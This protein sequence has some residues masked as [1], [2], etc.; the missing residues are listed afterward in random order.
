MKTVKD[1]IAMLQTLDQDTILICSKDA[2]GNSY[3][4][5]SSIGDGYYYV[6]ETTWSGDVYHIEDKDEYDAEEW[7]DI[8]SEGKP[9]VVIWPTN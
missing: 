7:D 2:E 4:P 9:A 8:L 5:F 1:L 6:P 3:S